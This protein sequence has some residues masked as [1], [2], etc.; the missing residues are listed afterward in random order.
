MRSWQLA[1]GS[2]AAGLALAAGAIAVA[3]PW[4]NGQRTAE[5]A[6]AAA[7][8]RSGAHHGTRPAGDPVRARPDAAPSAPGVLPGTVAPGT[9][10]AGAATGLAEALRPLLARPALGPGPAA[11]VVDAA[12]GRVLFAAG[13]GRPVTPASTIKIATAA[14][15]LSALGPEHRIETRTV[16]APGGPVVLV[17]GGDPTLTAR[18]GRTDGASLR[19]LA[20]DTAKALKAAGRTS[21]T[22]GYDAGLFTGPTAHPIG[23]GNEN[24]APV[25]AL[26]VDQGRL[27]A[28]T[29]GTAARGADP[30]A[31]AARAFAAGLAREGV[32]V[33][34]RPAPVKAAA[35]AAPLA[36]VRSA[37]LAVLVERMLTQSDNDIAEALA[38]QTALA[39]GAPA[40][41][42]GAAKAVTAR[43]AALGLPMAGTRFADGSGLD[44]RDR[45]TAAFLTALLAEAADPARPA[46][47]PLLTG[48]PVAGFTG[49]LRGRYTGPGTPPEPLAPGL[50][51]A[52]TGTL[53]GVNSLAGTVVTPSGRLLSFAFLAT[54]TPSAEQAQPALDALAAALVTH[55]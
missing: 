19:V 7:L 47:R 17:G 28:S 34:G 8:G 41:F 52:K 20:A 43:L 45:L 46:L 37:P 55:G 25:T 9:A 32:T 16:A 13:P 18:T 30:A 40:S 15:A 49:T 26:A 5:R 12:T 11:S 48:L 50:V 51:R 10:P 23:A 54:D 42:E 31:D 3:G 53:S 27:D 29:S 14:A 24:L 2:A 44:R 1:A 39:S 6:H 22:L 21:V 36:I 4:D 33:T 35:G 38:R